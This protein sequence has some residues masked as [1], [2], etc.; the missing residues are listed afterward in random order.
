M[1][2]CHLRL[3]DEKSLM[4]ALTSFFFSPSGMLAPN[5]DTE[6]KLL[7][8]SF[9]FQSDGK[10]IILSVYFIL[11]FEEFC[12]NL[13]FFPSSKADKSECHSIIVHDLLSKLFKSETD[14][15]KRYSTTRDIPMVRICG[16]MERV[17]YRTLL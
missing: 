9:H 12:L 2:S 14:W 15:L 7:D 5:D 3:F 6:Q 16:K 4:C 8:V 13:C 17:G 1:S 10:F 11:L